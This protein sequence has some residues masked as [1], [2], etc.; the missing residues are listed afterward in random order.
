V[1]VEVKGITLECRKFGSKGGGDEIVA[2]D[3]LA[4]VASPGGELGVGGSSASGAIT[5]R[6]WRR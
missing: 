3:G 4:K 1:L 2:A 5:W 6:A